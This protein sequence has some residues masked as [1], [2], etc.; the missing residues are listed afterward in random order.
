MILYTE[1]KKG[2]INIIIGTNSAPWWP[3]GFSLFAPQTAA[4]FY[5]MRPLKRQTLKNSQTRHIHLVIMYVE[6]NKQ[7]T[8]H[9]SFTL[10][11][12][13]RKQNYSEVLHI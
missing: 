12:H 4:V 9:P 1:I 5:S 6:Q 13:S 3:L 7:T 8:T 2:W 11:S 10:W